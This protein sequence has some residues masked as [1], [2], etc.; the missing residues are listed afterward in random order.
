MHE[1]AHLVEL[2]DLIERS[3]DRLRELRIGA[4]SF[5]HHQ[6]W[7]KM[8]TASLY[9]YDSG[10]MITAVIIA[11]LLLPLLLMVYLVYS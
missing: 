1:I 4:A 8:V 2:S 7:L 10:K 6:Y 3:V 9:H 5:E 11:S